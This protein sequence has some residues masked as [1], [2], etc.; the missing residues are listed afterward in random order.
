MIFASLYQALVFWQ[1]NKQ[2]NI[3]L[4]WVINYVQ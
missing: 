2:N 3:K 1:E 4:Q